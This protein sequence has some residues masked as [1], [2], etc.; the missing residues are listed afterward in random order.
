MRKTILITGASSGLGAGMARV[1]AARGHRLALCARRVDRLRALQAELVDGN[2]GADVHVRE[3]DVTD[4]DQVFAVFGEIAESL[5]GVD[6]VIANAGLGKGAPLGTGYFRANRQTAETNV[7]GLLA[8]C[9]AAME[10]FR[11][12]NQG[13][14]VVIASVSAR[15]GARGAMTTYAA[16]KAFA[17]SLAEG[18]RS[19]VMG[20]DIKVS[21]ILPGYIESEMTARAQ[22][23][24]YIVDNETGVRAIV[25]AIDREP[26]EAVVPTWPW[27]PLTAALR[28]LPLRVVRRLM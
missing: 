11:R 24:P 20:T 17:A 22:R 14:L 23:T 26:A 2:A 4:H 28:V 9:E 12:A 27:R 1:Y 16:T 5:G 6:R 15:R 13:H 10:I 19:D 8:Q 7:L 18:I 25:A 21:T 3:L